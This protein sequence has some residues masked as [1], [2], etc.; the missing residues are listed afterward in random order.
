MP[1]IDALDAAVVGPI[2][3]TD[4]ASLEAAVW[5]IPRDLA[6]FVFSSLITFAASS[7]FL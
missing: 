2:P 5:D 4:P 3:A 6:I 1:S 7:P